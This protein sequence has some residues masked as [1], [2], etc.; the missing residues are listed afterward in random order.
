[1]NFKE[2]SEL[3]LQLLLVIIWPIVAL[4][5]FWS[6]REPLK[7]FIG[8]I[9]KFGFG[10]FSAEATP[11]QKQ[12]KFGENPPIDSLIDKNINEPIE[13]ALNS[14]S[15]STI[16]LLEDIVKRATNIDALP[17]PEEKEKALLQYS[18]LAFL[19]LQFVAT[20]SNIYGSQIRL[21]QRLNSN[22]LVKKNELIW[23]YNSAKANSPKEYENYPYSEYLKFLIDA[24]LIQE[25]ENNVRITA[26]GRDFLKFLVSEAFNLEKA[27]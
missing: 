11:S 21:L 2:I 6:L 10:P 3:V 26:L 23:Y 9:K 22:T 27:F 16:I 13:T 18:K 14:Y 5:I 1:M 12:S 7:D 17:T 19:T 20:Y 24:H 8:K 25:E 15:K 4:I